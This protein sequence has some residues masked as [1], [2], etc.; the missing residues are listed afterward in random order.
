VN[1][2]EA[3]LLIGGGLAGGVANTL[4]GGGSLLTVPLLVLTGIPGGVA[5][6]TNRIGILAQS[7]SASWQFRVEGVSALR[8]AGAVL[9]PLGVGSALG[10]LAISR[11]PDA[12]FERL[13]AVLM[14]LLL[15]TLWPRR[16]GSGAPRA[17]WSA[18]RS[19]AVF[20]AIGAYA[21]AIQAG[22]G[23][24]LVFALRHAGFD[25]VR[26]NA[27]KMLVVGGVLGARIA[28]R[29]G[30]RAIRWCMGAAV[31]ALAGHMFGLY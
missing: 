21:G 24:A 28:V 17:P 9:V 1:A 8:E 18:A 23:I 2:G 27:I 20:L 11:V 4:A 14:L 15:P 7:A 22:V 10:A 16:G 19:R 26:A 29:R 13:Y 25:L 30:E 3:V 5:N 12:I 6:G 31:V